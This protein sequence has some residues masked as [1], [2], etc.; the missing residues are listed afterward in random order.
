MTFTAPEDMELE[1][2]PLR[3]ALID[4][5]AAIKEMHPC[6]DCGNNFPACCMDFDHRPEENKVACVG[7]LVFS[8][9]L[10][11]VEAEIAKCDL[12]CANCHR[13]RTRDRK[14][15]IRVAIGR[16]LRTG[17]KTQR[18]IAKL[19]GLSEG[20]ISGLKRAAAGITSKK[21]LTPEQR[22]EM[23][24]L[25]ANGLTHREIAQKLGCSSSHV[26]MVT[27]GLR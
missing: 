25:K 19:Y 4:Y 12:V 26:S 18:A 8:G 17:L 1:I 11:D 2:R 22:A 5:V 14:S 3:Y 16:E 13:I 7:R 23:C 15:R 24:N 21:Q 9:S 20:L 6:M 10:A 27:R